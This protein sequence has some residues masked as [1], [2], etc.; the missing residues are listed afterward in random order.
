MVAGE[1]GDLSNT[2]NARIVVRVK[3]LLTC[4]CTDKQKEAGNVFNNN[5]ETAKKKPETMNVDILLPEYIL[6]VGFM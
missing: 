2:I 6:G 1:R 4:T 3:G 5:T